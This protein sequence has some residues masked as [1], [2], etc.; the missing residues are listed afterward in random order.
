VRDGRLSRQTEQALV[1]AGLDVA[2]A[3]RVLRTAL[4]ED[5]GEAGDITSAATVDGDE[6]ILVAAYVSRSSGVVAG[7]PLIGATF[8]LLAPGEVRISCPA[9][10]GARVEPGQLLATVEAPARAILAAERTTLNLIGRLSGIA[11][12]TRR[13]ADAVDGTGARIRD[14]RKTTPGLRDLEKYAVRCGGGINHRRGLYDAYLIKDNHIAAAGGVGAALTRVERDR[15][16]LV[17]AVGAVEVQVEVDDLVQLAEALT[18]RPPSILLDNFTLDEL[19]AAVR[20]I[21]AVAPETTVEASGGLQ[22]EQAR[23]VAM[24]GVDYLAVGQLTHS[25]PQLDIGL[26]VHAD[27]KAPVS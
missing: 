20:V 10:D 24:T 27:V 18:H 16:S 8:D 1:E 7:L 26:D 9:H 6:Q 14:T 4:V 25:A 23:A 11:T 19:V 2:S 15:D 12:V 13:W 5:L 17:E 3:D 21:R 22:L